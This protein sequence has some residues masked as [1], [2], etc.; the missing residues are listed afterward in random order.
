M[1][2]K[3]QLVRKLDELERP[4]RKLNV[5]TFPD[6]F[7]KAVASEALNDERLGKRNWRKVHS[8]C[9]AHRPS[10]RSR[11][12]HTDDDGRR[13]TSRNSTENQATGGTMDVG[14]VPGHQREGTGLP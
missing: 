8:G 4:K 9:I 10:W 12:L 14:R 13:N 2:D 5:R 6:N 3:K 11:K 7:V 1:V